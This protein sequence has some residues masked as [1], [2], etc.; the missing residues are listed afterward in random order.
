MR[1]CHLLIALLAISLSGAVLLAEE[2]TAPSKVTIDENSK[3]LVCDGKKLFPIG[4]TMPPPPDGKTPDGKHGYDELRSAGAWF[5]RTGPSGG[6][7]WDDAWFETEQKYMDSAAKHGL[8]CAPW[9]KEASAVKDG[10][11]QKEEL[12]RKIINRF[13]D[14]PGLGV[15]KGEDEPQWGKKPIPPMVNAYKIIKQLDAN[16]PVWIVEA[17][18]G[19]TEQLATYN[20]TKDITGID[21]YPIS[22]PPGV[23]TEKPNKELSMVGD[24]TRQIM[25]AADGKRPVW[26][27]LQIAFS[28]V[29]KPGKTLRFPTFF[30]ERFMAYEA[31]INGARGL[32]FFG[33]NLPVTLNPRDKELGW[34]WTFW[35][36]VMRPVM[37][38]IGEFSP[39]QP[40]LVAANSTL[41]VKCDAGKDVELLVREV[42]DEIYVLACRAH[43]GTSE[44]SFTGL[45]ANV[46]P[47]AEVMFESPRM[48]DV[49]DGGFKDWF[50][51]FEVHVYKVTRQ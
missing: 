21:I 31:I 20:V 46:S 26:M 14:H 37:E 12:L 25:Q 17:P 15:W 44:V 30:E 7:D 3:V 48:V 47:K 34:N 24:F 29:T 51:P 1:F 9:L 28:G 35:Q 2:N 45:P 10:D 27:T 38:E 41:P 50:A 19:T 40:A 33:G 5:F 39:L 42:G 16:H 11:K 4:F 49:K 36:R 32:V 6:A 22:Y 13:K 8:H 43:G 23:H 18:R